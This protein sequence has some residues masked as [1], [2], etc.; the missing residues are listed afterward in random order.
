MLFVLGKPIQ[1]PTLVATNESNV[2]KQ[3]QHPSGPHQ[4]SNKSAIHLILKFC[5]L[6]VYGCFL[7]CYKKTCRH[8]KKLINSFRQHYS[9]IHVHLLHF[10]D[11]FAQIKSRGVLSLCL[12]HTS[13]IP[14]RHPSARWSP[15]RAFRPTE[16]QPA[17]H[18][19]RHRPAP[20][21]ISP[22]PGG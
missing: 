11:N 22:R 12:L 13:F 3:H 8:E 14:L 15:P 19:L 5:N 21:P 10:R 16:L 6:L 18:R 7:D 1:D 17:A 4:Y 2:R 9:I 20:S